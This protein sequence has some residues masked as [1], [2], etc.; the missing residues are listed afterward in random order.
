VLN[1]NVRH[2]GPRLTDASGRT[3]LRSESLVDVDLPPIYGILDIILSRK[4]EERE[5]Q[6]VC[7]ERILIVVDLIV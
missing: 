2:H 1:S 7:M 6:Y 3:A 4:Q 5:L